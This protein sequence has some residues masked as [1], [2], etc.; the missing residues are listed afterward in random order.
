ML[1]F[2][3]VICAL[4]ESCVPCESFEYSPVMYT[5]SRHIGGRGSLARTIFQRM[6]VDEEHRHDPHTYWYTVDNSKLPQEVCDNF[7]ELRQDRETSEFLEN[8][9]EKADWVFVQ[10]YHSLAKAVLSWFMP[11]T[12]INGYLNRGS[13]FVFSQSQFEQ[14]LDI[15]ADWQANNLLDLGAGDGKVTMKMAPHFNNV[16]TTETSN[17]MVTRLTEKGFINLGLDQWDS[18]EIKYDVISCLNLL[19]RCDRPISI[20]HSIKKSLAPNGQ[21]IVAI[22]LPFKPYVEFGAKDHQPTERIY[23]KGS[24]FE[25][26][27][28]SLVKDI[29]EPA[30]F[31]LVRMTRLPYLCEGDMESSFY[32]LDDAVFVLKLREELS[33]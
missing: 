30:G 8:C 33:E 3:I 1:S 9:Y 5:Y 10:I 24:H 17:M 12:S 22:V 4:C 25:E 16:Y 20:L 18:G 28:A 26:Q 13:M 31:S 11:V 19:D 14:L 21:V 29:F 6:Q 2:L 7:L 32:V 15:S 23:L 27:S